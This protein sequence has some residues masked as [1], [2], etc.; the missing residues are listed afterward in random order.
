MAN[1][2]TVSRTVNNINVTIEF[3]SDRVSMEELARIASGFEVST[4]RDEKHEI[5]MLRRKL[6]E[7]QRDRDVAQKNLDESE[8]KLK[9]A[10][11]Q[12]ARLSAQS[13]ALNRR[14]TALTNSLNA[15][16]DI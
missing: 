4:D 11:S 1:Q 5:E 3:V 16:R 14:M 15:M 8:S 13:T 10:Y 12:N 6:A 2:I 9:E 7:A